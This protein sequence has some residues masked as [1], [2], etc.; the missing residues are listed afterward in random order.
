MLLL[1]NRKNKIYFYFSIFFLF[2]TIF[3]VNLSNFLSEEFNIKYIE[4]INNNL[5]IKEINNL[6][7]K[8][9]F[10]IDTKSTSLA[11]TNNPLIKYFEIKKIY[12]STLKVN[13]IETIPIARVIG[14]ENDLYI[15]DN[16]RV[17]KSKKIFSSIPNISGEINLKYINNILQI[18]KNSPFRIEN[19]NSIKIYPSNRIDIIFNNKRII[20]FPVDI[21]NKFMEYAF[22]IYNHSDMKNLIDLRLKKRIITSR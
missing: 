20:K 11:I 2:T 18:L 22:N 9:I 4:N 21:D 16:G 13:L 12:P 15:G 1:K 10:E 7:N 19:M 8:S 3:N 17:F 5:T 14:N 6:K